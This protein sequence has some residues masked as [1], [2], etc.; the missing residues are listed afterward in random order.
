M[1]EHTKPREL[2]F[3]ANDVNHRREIK[4]DAD[5]AL[6]TDYRGVALECPDH[7]HVVALAY[8]SNAVRAL[9]EIAAEL[10][11]RL[12]KWTLEFDP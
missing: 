6:L 9:E 10:K 1:H 3:R 11:G 7:L 4:L 12:R 8:E 5:G 2:F